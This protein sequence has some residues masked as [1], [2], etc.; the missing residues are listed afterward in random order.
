MI[1]LKYIISSHLPAQNPQGPQ[2]LP[3][4]SNTGYLSVA[5]KVLQGSATQPRPRALGRRPPAHPRCTDAPE[6]LLFL[7][8]LGPPAAP[9]L[10]ASASR[11][12]PPS[13]LRSDLT[14]SEMH[15]P[16]SDP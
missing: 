14:F 5:F 1:L 11:R 16:G 13:G 2:W 9:D 8:R 7:A 12:P 6:Q 3:G 4:H 15:F 10:R